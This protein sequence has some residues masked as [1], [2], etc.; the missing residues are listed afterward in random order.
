MSSTSGIAR[1]LL[2]TFGITGL[3]LGL[4]AFWLTAAPAVYRLTNARV[5]AGWQ[6]EAAAVAQASRE[7]DSRL[8]PSSRQDAY[9]L[10]YQVGYCSNI[11]GSVALQPAEVQAR[12]TAVLAPQL[13]AVDD[14]ARELMVDGVSLLRVTNV[15]EFGR[16]PD[17]LDA[18][19]LG[20]A[21]RLE[22]VTSR[23]H[24]HL[25]LLG[26][27]VGAGA[28][29]AQ[30][31]GGRLHE[32]LRPLAGRHATLAAVPKTAWEPVTVA[33]AGA[34]PEQRLEVYQ[35]ALNALDTAV[36]ALEPLR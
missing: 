4:N 19:E 14:L 6:R 3:Y 28:A 16:V 1:F 17:R 20:L 27:Q 33:P 30:M 24:R 32:Q 9:R 7:A 5:E 10:G 26:M 23:R 35:N 18:D 22:T 34:T 12:F 31:T 2:V 21:A 15:D 13:R 11:M 29:L 25:L 36:G 8:P